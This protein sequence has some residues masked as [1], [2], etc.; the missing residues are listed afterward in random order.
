MLDYLYD[1]K[2]RVNNFGHCYM[3]NNNNNNNNNNCIMNHF[4]ISNKAK[5]ETIYVYDYNQ[6]Y[7]LKI[8][9]AICHT[10]NKEFQLLFE[11]HLLFGYV[12]Y[13]CYVANIAFK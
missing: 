4:Y 6:I 1:I 13:I 8:Y 3:N 10:H 7:R 9:F 2:L 5:C 11:R 12:F